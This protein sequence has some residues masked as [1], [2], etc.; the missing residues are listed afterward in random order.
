MCCFPFPQVRCQAASRA[1]A[2]LA[3][4]FPDVR[5]P[6]AP[7]PAPQ[8]DADLFLVTNVTQLLMGELLGLVW[9][10]IDFCHPLGIILWEHQRKWGFDTAVCVKS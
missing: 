5:S 3:Q 8:N 9:V 10:I 6:C 2:G 4:T 1:A 7:F